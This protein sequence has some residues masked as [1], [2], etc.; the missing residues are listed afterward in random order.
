MESTS[1]K[2]IEVEYNTKLKQIKNYME[3]EQKN[4]DKSYCW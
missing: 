1:E 2:H 3:K 4:G